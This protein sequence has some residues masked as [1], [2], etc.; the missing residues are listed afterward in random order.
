[1]QATLNPSMA[2]PKAALR[3]A[4]PAPTTTGSS[5]DR[6]AFLVAAA[7]SLLPTVKWKPLDAVAGRMLD[8]SV[9]IFLVNWV[10]NFPNDA[11]VIQIRFT[12]V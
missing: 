2:R 11:I 9:R 5:R 3:P 4:P 12:S 1:M 8:C 6:A 7:V 10:V